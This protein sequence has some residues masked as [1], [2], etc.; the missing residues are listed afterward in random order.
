MTAAFPILGDAGYAAYL[1][2]LKHRG[3]NPTT[4]IADI[5]YPDQGAPVASVVKLMNPDGLLAC[6]E[7]L[8]WMFLNAASVQAPK[9]AAL[10]ALTEKKMVMVLGR[11]LVQKAWVNNGHVL[12]WASQQLDFRSIQALFAGSAADAK[13][14]EVLRTVEGAAIAAF[15]ET[16][17]NIDRNTG[18]MLFVSHRSCVPVDHELC[19]AMQNWILGEIKHVAM[20]GD[21]L[22]TLKNAAKAG[23]ISRTE[24]ETAY[25][26]M[27]F[28]SQKHADALKKCT[29]H[30]VDLLERFFPNQATEL[31]SRVLSFIATRTARQWM[32]DRLGVV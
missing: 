16:F 1:G 25:N 4:H 29:S 3:A 22:R 31:T 15:D 8:A 26:R 32:A 6:N 24:L 2:P 18:N 5:R 11:K 7:A 19:F 17:L 9:N 27:V 21:S 23:K 28:H 30:M 13:W 12:A 14:L 10:L 20:D